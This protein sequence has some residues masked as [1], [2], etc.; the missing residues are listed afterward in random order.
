M[1]G[2]CSAWTALRAV[3]KLYGEVDWSW[4]RVTA[5]LWIPYSLLAATVATIL[6]GSRL[7]NGKW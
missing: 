6:I 3:R 1:M 7:K 5:P 2:L 4:K